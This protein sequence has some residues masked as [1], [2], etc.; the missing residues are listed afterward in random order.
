MRN[1]ESRSLGSAHPAWKKLDH[2]SR[3]LYVS[4]HETILP[5]LLRNYDRYSMANGVEIRMPFMDHRIVTFAFALP[6]TSKLRNGFSKAIIRYGLSDY[7]PEEIAFRRSKI[8]FNSPIVDWIKGPLKEY[9]L[10]LLAS[11]SFS[12][13]GLVN[14]L[15][16]RKIFKLVIDNPNASFLDG[17]KAWTLLTPFLWEQAVLKNHG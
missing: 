2:L 13:C 3:R 1:N 15:A 11:K 12:E 14:H 6:W 9:F 16:I 4:T 10:D 7:I 17:E 5:T 8:G